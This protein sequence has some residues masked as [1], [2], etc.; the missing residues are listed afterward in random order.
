MP[1]ASQAPDRPATPA[2]EGPRSATPMVAHRGWSLRI[3]APL[4]LSLPVLAVAIVIL[5]IGLIQGRFAVN[6]LTS[7]NLDQ[8]HSRIS[9]HLDRLLSLPGQVTHLNEG[10]MS[11]RRLDPADLRGW[12]HPLFVQAQAFPELSSITWET[13]DGQVVWVAR[14]PRESRVI[15]G[16]KDHQT[17]SDVAEHEYD[18]GGLPTTRPFRSFAY[19]PRDWIPYRAAAAG[20]TGWADPVDWIDEHNNVTAVALAYVVPWMDQGGQFFGALTAQFTLDDIGHFLRSL[21]TTDLTQSYILNRDGDLI[22]TSIEQSQPE[23]RTKAEGSRLPLIAESA[24]HLRQQVGDWGRLQ[25]FH[26]AQLQLGDESYLARVTPLAHRSGLNWLIVT[27][28]PA[29]QLMAEIDS[30]R[31]WGLLA[32]AAAAALMVALGILLALRLVRPILAVSDHVG[33]IG[34]GDFDT[35]LTLR[36]SPEFSEM[37]EAINR[38]SRDLKD[39]MQLRLSLALAREVQQTFLPS[40]TPIVPGLQIASRSLYCEQTGG[41]YYDFL[42]PAHGQGLGIVV[43]DVT[44]HGIPAAMLMATARGILRSQYQTCDSLP[45]LL[46]HLNSMLTEVGGGGRFMTMLLLRIDAARRELRWASAGHG[47]PF[48]FDPSAQCFLKLDVSNLP[49]GVESAEQFAEHALADLPPGCIIVAATDGL[50]ET[51]DKQDEPFGQ[52]RLEAL[53][54]QHHRGS[55]EDLAIAIE[56]ALSSFRGELPQQDDVTFVIVKLHPF[57]G[58]QP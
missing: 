34:S 21:P 4:L 45:Q 2:G 11:D 36:V 39:R 8:I 27:L 15:L 9:E 51:M 13:R 5:L 58:S 24:R 17:G 29:R 18:P 43:G 38:M 52:G 35:P 23:R 54:R 57:P 14:Y 30:A 48:V 10:L 41:D 28:T 7:R 22:A 3:T 50:W 32:A 26:E 20:K 33:R 44:G 53:V 31:R 42:Q 55:A 40:R 19:D 49:L 37:S 46:E 16:I 56:T 12:A 1:S 47:W 6:R 25:Q